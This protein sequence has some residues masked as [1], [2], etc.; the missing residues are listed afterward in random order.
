MIACCI[1][2]K[3]QMQI[4]AR[5]VKDQDG[6]RTS[7]QVKTNNR[8]KEKIPEK[9]LRYFPL[10]PRLQRLYMSRRIATF[11]TWHNDGRVDDRL[12]W[13]PADSKA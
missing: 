8:Q 6:S 11:L 5:F 3:K 12:M 2:K 7:T 10:K 1:G 13:H 4:F 9:T